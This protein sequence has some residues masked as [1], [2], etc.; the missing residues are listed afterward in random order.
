VTPRLLRDAQ[1]LTVWEGTAN[2]LA[3]ELVRLVRKFNVHTLFVNSMKS[4]LERIPASSLKPIVVRVLDELDINLSIFADLEERMQ[5]FEAK[6]LAGRM[7]L[8][9]ESV[10]ALEMAD[11]MD[12]RTALLVDI[13]LDTTWGLRKLGDPM[14]TCRLFI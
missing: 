11:T 8:V 4:R 9:Y 10:V 2:I 12:E 5:T 6:S 13:Y 14:K 7:A 3:L 1:V